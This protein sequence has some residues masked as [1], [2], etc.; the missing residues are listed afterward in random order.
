MIDHHIKSGVGAASVR[1]IQPEM[2]IA[3]TIVVAIFERHG[4]TARLSSGVDGKHMRGSSHYRGHAV[5]IS[6]RDVP[7]QAYAQL[8]Q[9]MTEALGDEFDVI[10]EP[11][12]WH[13]QFRPKI[14]LN[15]GEK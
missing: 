3:W 14:P 11:S 2:A 15:I 4:V 13:I 7:S 9:A 1:G 8:G 5:D 10:E 12:H 6:K